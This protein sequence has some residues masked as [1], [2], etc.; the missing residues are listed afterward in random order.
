MSVSGSQEVK[1][2]IITTADA[3]NATVTTAL[4]ATEDRVI[5]SVTLGVVGTGLDEEVNGQLRIHIGAQ[6]GGQAADD[7]TQGEQ[8]FERMGVHKTAD[9]TN[10]QSS[11]APLTEYFNYD[12]P[13]NW[14]ED[15]TLTLRATENGGQAGY[16]GQAI[17]KYREL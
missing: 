10:G 3:N 12:P 17:V 14:N 11:V 6:P 2:A 5:E 13:I 8:F 15:A 1:T 4:D 7:S 9:A 16:N